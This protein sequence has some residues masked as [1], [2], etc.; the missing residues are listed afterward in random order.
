MIPEGERRG[1]PLAEGVRHMEFASKLY[2][3]Q[4]EEGGNLSMIIM[5]MPGPGHYLVYA[6]PCERGA[7][8]AAADQCMFGVRFSCKHKSQLVLAP[9]PTMLMT[10]SQAIWR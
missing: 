2:Q 1:K 4:V 7:G 3:K 5:L 8:I 6:R 10:N 9:E